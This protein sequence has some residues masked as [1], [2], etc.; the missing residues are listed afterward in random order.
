MKNRFAVLSAKHPQIIS[1]HGD[2]RVLIMSRNVK[3]HERKV[4]EKLNRKGIRLTPPNQ[5]KCVSPE[6]TDLNLKADLVD[7]IAM[8]GD[9]P[10]ED[11]IQF[12][13]NIL[14]R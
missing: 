14:L 6:Q 7:I 1:P 9:I 2:R 5:I 4:W 13:K 10:E 3:K 11:M 12:K 8:K